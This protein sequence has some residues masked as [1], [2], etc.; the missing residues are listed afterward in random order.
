[1]FR[2]RRAIAIL[3]GAM[4]LTLTLAPAASAASSATG[5][6]VIVPGGGKITGTLKLKDTAAAMPSVV[7]TATPIS[8]GATHTATSNA[9]GVFTVLGLVV[10]QPY[11]LQAAGTASYPAGFYTSVNADHFTQ[12]P[13]S[14]VPTPAATAAGASVG[15]MLV[16]KG[17]T[18]S[19]VV[20]GGTTA[21]SAVLPGITVGLSSDDYRY[22]DRQAV[23]TSTGAFSFGGLATGTYRL[24]F[25]VPDGAN[26]V[27][28]V[29][30]V[31]GVGN[32]AS[33]SQSTVT[34]N[35]SASI[36]I[37]LPVGKTVTGVLKDQ[38]GVAIPGAN[39]RFEEVV[40]D[41]QSH[42]TMTNAAGTYVIKGLRANSSG[43]LLV[44]P[45]N[46]LNQRG[47]F[48][49]GV[50]GNF[51]ADSYRTPGTAL[52]IGTADVT[53]PEIRSALLLGVTGYV[54]TSAGVG[55]P[56]VYVSSNDDGTSTDATGRYTLHMGPSS[57]PICV[58]P[59]AA[60]LQGGC[61]R[62][63]ASGNFA[64]STEL[65]SNV[66]V[67]ANK[68]LADVKVPAGSTITGV[69][70]LPSGLPAA[71]APVMAQR[72]CGTAWCEFGWA[73]TGSN[74]AFTLTG[75]W[76]GTYTMQVGAPDASTAIGGWFDTGTVTT[77]LSVVQANAD[78][79]VLGYSSTS[80]AVGT[81][82]LLA[83]YSISG[84]I[85]AGTTTSSVAL[86]GATVTFTQVGGGFGGTVGGSQA[87][88]GTTHRGVQATVGATNK[89]VPTVGASDAAGNAAAGGGVEPQ[90]TP[91][92]GP[93]TITTSTGTYKMSGLTAGWYLLGVIPKASQNYETGYRMAGISP[94]YTR[95]P[96]MA[97]LVCVGPG[98]P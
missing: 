53:V 81:I 64:G 3:A 54:K 98:C 30:Q 67:L 29:Y 28:G 2:R 13:G 68:T 62:E 1:M 20:K 32:W 61:F 90:D 45:N 97:Q 25:S 24:S 83:G 38:A 65:A 12:F 35:A 40:G 46:G 89:G 51:A 11:I 47:Y 14:A 59:Y 95:S 50:T 87:A 41:G 15:T 48:R 79:K 72:A 34:L 63:G 88:S 39:V 18:I 33:S 66:L 71:D 31:N 19:G 76:P 43:T 7:V 37:I 77:H 93:S 27:S 82:R 42:Q 5:I 75:L 60:N 74:G 8:G 94:N 58:W 21:S 73:Y 80:W 55:I 70:Q 92:G 16:P 49:A 44:D 10:G 22:V 69:V 17:L 91:Y 23:T 96:E 84:T 85:K 78:S 26:Y 86:A 9:S 52:V 4:V 56:D 6:N 57:G 36:G